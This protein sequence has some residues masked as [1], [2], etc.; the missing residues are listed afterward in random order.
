[1]EPWAR[2]DGSWTP[3]STAEHARMSWRPS[4]PNGY[5]AGGCYPSSLFVAFGLLAHHVAVWSQSPSSLS[6]S[7][8]TSR[9]WLWV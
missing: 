9:C 3:V 2:S 8:L 1:M 5:M 4:T 7:L 6:L